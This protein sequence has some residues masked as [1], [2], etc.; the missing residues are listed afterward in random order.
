VPAYRMLFLRASRLEGWK[1]IEADNDL[2]AVERAA[3]CTSDAKVELWRDD[4]TLA[5]FRAPRGVTV[6]S[7][8]D[9]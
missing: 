8:Q 9:L 7:E 3:R 1:Q 4:K 2:A 6:N 5:T